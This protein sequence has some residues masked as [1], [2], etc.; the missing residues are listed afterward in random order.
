MTERVVDPDLK[1]AVG[2]WMER[3]V[4]GL[5]ALGALTYGGDYGVYVARG[6]PQDS[7]NVDQMLAVPLK[8]NKTEFDYQGS[9]PQGCARALF[10]QGGETPCWYLRRH[11]TQTQTF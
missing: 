5:I 7:V 2:R 3:A 8:G 4:I 9:A 6:K 1:R 11:K 10:P